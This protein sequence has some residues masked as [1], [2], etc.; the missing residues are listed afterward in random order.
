VVDGYGYN[1]QVP[2][3]VIE[4]RQGE[5]LEIR[6]TN[7]LPEPTL[8]HWHGLRI[9]A[10][11]D[12]TQHQAVLGPVSAWRSEQEARRSKVREIGPAYGQLAEL[13]GAPLRMRTCRAPS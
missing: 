12:G 10:P 2:G 6:F 13:G 7:R 4:A 9:P 8:I 3:P 1:N 5:P 11:M